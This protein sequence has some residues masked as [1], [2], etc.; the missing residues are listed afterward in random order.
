ME[1]VKRRKFRGSPS[2]IN[3]QM[4]IRFHMILVFS[5][6]LYNRILMQ[7]LQ[8]DLFVNRHR[9]ASNNATKQSFFAKK[10]TMLIP[11]FSNTNLFLLKPTRL[12]ALNF[13]EA[14]INSEI[15]SSSV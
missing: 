5:K 11:R 8:S 1:E 15:S 2:I 4:F 6:N 10:K 14:I 9:V 3:V 12:F 7:I 13:Y